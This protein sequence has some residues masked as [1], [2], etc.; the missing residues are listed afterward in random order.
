VADAPGAG[1][2]GRLAGKRALVTGG[3]SGIGAEVVRRF[4]EEGADVLAADLAGGD[5]ECDVRSKASVDAAVAAA[6]E[7]LGGLDTLVLNAGRPVVGALHELAEEDWDDG[8]ATNL[9]SI[10]LFARAAWGH[11]ARSGGSISI[12]ASVVGLWGSQNQAAYCATKAAAVMLAKCLALDGAAAGIRANCV[13]PGFVQTPLLERFLA[14]QDDPDAVRAGATALHPLGRL[15]RARDVADA[16]VYLA[17]V[18]AAWVTGT[19]LVVDGG[20]TAGIH[21]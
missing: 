15:G 2:G 17:S 12:T 19:A 5:L 8:I 13:C 20:L 10:H 3:G 16:F 1:A 18:E 11:L 14:E 6:V 9:T 21:G 7:R 4:R